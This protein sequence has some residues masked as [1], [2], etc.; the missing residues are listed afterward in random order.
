[1]T[2]AMDRTLRWLSQSTAEEAVAAVAP[3][4]PDL[5]RAVITASLARYQALEL[6][7]GPLLPRE[8]F[9]R[10]KHSMLSGGAI[11]RDIPYDECVDVSLA[12]RAVAGRSPA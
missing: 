10:L 7:S 9:D 6:W 11:R 4:F 8:G 12:S 2:R 1:M 5:D 3:Y